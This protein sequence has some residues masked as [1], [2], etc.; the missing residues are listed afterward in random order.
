MCIPTL[1]PV[2]RLLWIDN[3]VA[4][5]T[6]FLKYFLMQ[7]QFVLFIYKMIGPFAPTLTP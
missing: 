2:T 7:D 1:A 3:M 6:H 5:N 4:W